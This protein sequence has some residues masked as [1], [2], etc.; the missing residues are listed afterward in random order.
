MFRQ[1][2]LHV[3]SLGILKQGHSPI[4]S[5]YQFR[6]IVRKKKVEQKLEKLW[7]LPD[8]AP[9]AG[10]CFINFRF[11]IRCT[12]RTCF[13]GEKRGALELIVAATG[14][15]ADSN[16]KLGKNSYV[17]LTIQCL[18]LKTMSLIRNQSKVPY[19]RRIGY[20]D[21]ILDCRTAKIGYKVY[22]ASWGNIQE[23]IWVLR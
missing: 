20:F 13:I 18:D 16:Q 19:S 3:V 8:I 6:W 21:H 12:A 23:W 7:H 2:K 17:R 22:L 1:C 10:N 9:R 11:S 5:H 4:Y 15:T 14:K